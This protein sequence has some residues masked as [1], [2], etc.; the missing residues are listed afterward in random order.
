MRM[1]K[2][3]RSLGH[4]S[5]KGHQLQY[6]GINLV[7][8]GIYRDKTHVFKR[9]PNKHLNP[10]E[11]EVLEKNLYYNIPL[12]DK[13]VDDEHTFLVFPYYS[14]GDLFNHL[15]KKLPL[16][17]EESKKIMIKLIDLLVPFHQEG[18]IHL[19]LKL[20]N[21]IHLNEFYQQ[22]KAKDEKIYDLFFINTDILS[23][24]KPWRGYLGRKL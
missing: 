12:V 20:E 16:E 1:N 14:R 2:F 17:E 18:Y 23:S 11:L 4:M 22:V 10:L 9:I 3:L 8:T 24:N 15:Q 6:N 21:F 13:H 7:T 19:D 5:R